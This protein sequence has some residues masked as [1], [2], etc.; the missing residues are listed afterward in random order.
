MAILHT[1]RKDGT[2]NTKTVSLTPRSAIK[3]FCSEC[4]KWRNV[5]LPYV[6]FF[7]LGIRELQK[8]PER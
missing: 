6:L 8:E 3:A 2:G 4:M 5:L 7:L 1:I